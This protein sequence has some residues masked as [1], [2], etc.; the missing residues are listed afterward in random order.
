[1]FKPSSENIPTAI[2]EVDA[3]LKLFFVLSGIVAVF[4]AAA[5]PQFI[6]PAAVLLSLLTVCRSFRPYLRMIYAMRWFLLFVFLLHL[7][8]SPG[9]TLFGTFFLS[10]DGALRGLLIS[11]Q[12]ALA[13]G[14]SLLLPRISAPDDLAAAFASLLSPLKMFGLKTDRLAEQLLLTMHVAPIV[15]DEGVAAW[16]EMR[17]ARIKTDR[18]G[19]SDFAGNIH[20]IIEAMLNRMLDRIDILAKMSLSGD[21]HLPELKI[22]SGLLLSPQ[23]LGAAILCAGLVV[24]TLWL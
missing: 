1:M 2:A 22:L 5:P 3:R 8:L 12:V 15:Q 4:S 18:P 19:L 6:L 24:N 20:L 23:N 11:A 16:S 10:Y 13:A 17:A 9:R 7:L 21:S 14:F